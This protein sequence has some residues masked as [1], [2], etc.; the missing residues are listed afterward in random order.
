MNINEKI[1]AVYAYDMCFV[2]EK[3]QN[4][5]ILSIDELPKI[6]EEFKKFFTLVLQEESA[7]A[8]IDKR[9]DELWHSFILFTPQYKEFCD[10]IMGFFVHHQPRTSFT[11]VPINSIANFVSCY[12]KHFGELDPFWLETLDEDIKEVVVSGNIPE[13]LTTKWS[14]WTGKHVF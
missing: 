7:L 4:D 8:M 13:T 3:I 14:G 1:R 10:N 6:E 5:K 11:P 12:K 2:H 9:V